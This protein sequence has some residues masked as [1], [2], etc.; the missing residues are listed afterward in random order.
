MVYG[1]V[2][3]SGS[4]HS[5]TP[6]SSGDNAGQGY[7][8]FIDNINVVDLFEEA[9]QYLVEENSTDSNDDD[10]GGSKDFD[11]DDCLQHGWSLP[12][13][14]LLCKAHILIRPLSPAGK[15]APLYLLH[16]VFRI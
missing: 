12:F 10:N 6:R 4:N 5:P 11:D 16:R 13:T 2:F 3:Y 15:A 7:F 8:A 1:K 9:F 14:D